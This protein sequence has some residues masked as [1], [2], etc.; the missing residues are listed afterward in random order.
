M[1]I[2]LTQ[3]GTWLASIA[4]GLTS[5]YTIWKYA[6]APIR[7][8]VRRLNES[9]AFVESTAKK[10]DEIRP[11][12]DEIT[13]EFRPNGG[14]SIRDRLNRIE[15][16]LQKKDVRYRVVLD[17][18]HLGIFECD[19]TG[20][21]TYA[22]RTLCDWFE[23][24][25]SEMLGNGW[26]AAIKAEEREAVHSNWK[27]AALNDIPWSTTYTVVPVRGGKSYTAHAK[28]VAIRDIDG[29]IVVFCGTVQR[30]SPDCVSTDHVKDNCEGCAGHHSKK[31]P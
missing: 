25:H 22:N 15:V 28:A 7:R 1:E 13:H 2:D 30:C 26:L 23:M 31:Q 17:S 12:V 16:D 11:L 21:C 19:A 18:A 27:D 20:A 24:Q 29:K 10:L 14:K 9:M 4:G 8:G 3:I 6:V 5:L